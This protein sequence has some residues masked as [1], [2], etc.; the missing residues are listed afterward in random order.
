MYRHQLTDWY[1]DLVP[2]TFMNISI[3]IRVAVSLIRGKI[4][5]NNII[6]KL[7]KTTRLITVTD[8]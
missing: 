1:A 3:N 6:E 5:T 8:I 4:M 7:M 2:K